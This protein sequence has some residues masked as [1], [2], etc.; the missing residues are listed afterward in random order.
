MTD[1]IKDLEEIGENLENWFSNNKIKLNTNKCNLILNSQYA[2]N[3]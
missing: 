3:R 2:Q 1:N